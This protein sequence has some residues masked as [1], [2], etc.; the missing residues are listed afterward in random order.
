M[1]PNVDENLLAWVREVRGNEQLQADPTVLEE[2][3]AFL[4]NHEAQ[5][6]RSATHVV[7]ENYPDWWARGRRAPPGLE[8]EREEDLEEL[9]RHAGT[10]FDLGI[11][12]TLAERRTP[13]FRLFQDVE[14]WGSREAAMSAEELI[15]P[16]TTLTRFIGTVIGEVFPN[17]NGF[18]DAAIYDATGLSQT[19]GVR[20]TSLRF[21][22]PGIVVD[23]DRAARV[24]DLLVHKL[25]AAASDGGAI[26]DLEAQLRESSS[27]NAWHSVLG[28][29]AYAGRSNVR[30]PL[31]DRVSPL[32][33]RAP[34]HRPLAPVGVMRF[35]FGSEGKMKVEWLCRQAELDGAEWVKIGSV[36][37]LG[38]VQLS[39]WTV[40]AL[41][42]SQP[43]PTSTTRTGRVKVRTAGGSD[44]GA[45]MRLKAM[46]AVPAAERAGQLLT[47]ERR[48]NGAADQFCE[49][50]EQHL[51]KATVEPDGAL[52]W[53]QPNGDARI[54]MYSDDK[55]VK[56]IGRPN[57]V[58]SLVVVVAP[59]T[60]A[61]SNL[62]PH[63]RAHGAGPQ[64]PD[65][66]VPSEAYAPADAAGNDDNG[67][68]VQEAEDAAERDAQSLAG[69]MRLVRQDF[70]PQGQ[71][72]L[73]LTDGDVV[74]ITHDPEGEHGSSQ[75]RWVYGR[76]EATS[77]VGWFPLSHTIV[78]EEKA[79]N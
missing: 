12:L 79:G 51:G 11:P 78:L 77:Q 39:E 62:G 22:W 26:A 65:G 10:L 36:R 75:D 63:G 67:V 46:K 56:V 45:A 59:Y 32:P 29:A 14:A 19:K 24:R 25:A 49:K 64:M 66:R 72:E 33:L 34:E 40:P 58:R 4:L 55:R 61:Q 71:G 60:E 30:M 31:S 76:S 47:V 48:F 20:K 35:A 17:H 8:V 2:V 1:A 70:E 44:G 7:L 21:V 53:K 54:V 37:Q 43:I 27:A 74:C 69:H 38:N 52:V 5:S 18:L 50:M 41:S 57:Q 23:T 42:V 3:R 16:D 6:A 68:A 28:D 13:L 9:Y 73:A 15:G